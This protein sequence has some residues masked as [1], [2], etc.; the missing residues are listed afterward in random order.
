MG[1]YRYDATPINN[2]SV[3]SIGSQGSSQA[4]NI[5]DLVREM[6][7][8]AKKY[9]L[10]MG[11]ANAASGTNT[12]ALTLNDS[13][14]TAYFDGMMF[15][16]VAPNT[17]T[18]SA[19][20]LNVN[21]IGA[22][23]IRK[24]VAGVETVLAIGDI[25]A[26]QLYSLR[27][28]SAW[29]AGAGAWQ[30]I[31]IG[32]IV[33]DT[34]AIGAP[35]GSVMPFAGTVEPAGWVFAAGQAISR[36]T[37][38]A[39]FAAIGTTYGAGDGSTTFNVPDLRGRVTAG[40]DNMGGTAANRLTNQSGGVAGTLAATGGS[41]THTL[42]TPQ[43]P[44]HNHTATDSGHQHGVIS[45]GSAVQ[46]QGPGGGWGGNVAGGLSGVGA[47]NITVGNTGGGGA[48]NNVQPTIVL[49]YIIKT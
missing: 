18:L 22:R 31:A 26:G 1:F 13:T 9:V 38:A 11:G 7:A 39:L 24:S 28:R 23:A 2:T 19:A 17:S 10:D 48:H 12:Y 5:D 20:T 25:K 8:D 49:N 36:T 42:T 3:G 37:F 43:I 14:V 34:T 32:E 21:G 16:M 45:S 47:A 40:R 15:S 41:E 6:V 27:F 30:L 44:A 35:A 4:N 33:P 29:N 46:L